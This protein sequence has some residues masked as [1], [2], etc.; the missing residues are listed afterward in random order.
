MNTVCT[1]VPVG[2]GWGIGM[3]GGTV[4]MPVGKIGAEIVG[5]GEG[6]V[7]LSIGK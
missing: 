2:G 3:K 5:E 7:S 6:G 4:G 1:Y